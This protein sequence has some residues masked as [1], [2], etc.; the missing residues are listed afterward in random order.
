M[1]VF[2]KLDG[3]YVWVCK[4][5]FTSN[6]NDK[7]FNKKAK[8]IDASRFLAKYP[9]ERVALL[10]DMIRIKEINEMK[11]SMFGPVVQ[12]IPDERFYLS[13]C[14]MGNKYFPGFYQDYRKKKEA[15]EYGAK[16]YGKE[17]ID[18]LIKDKAFD[19]PRGE[20]DMEKLASGDYTPFEFSRFYAN[21]QEITEDEYFSLIKEKERLESIRSAER[22]LETEIKFKRR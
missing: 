9:R 6:F 19:E 21:S 5:A 13:G 7:E 12:Y 18:K 10:T 15:L 1:A 20:K 14:H 16:V 11:P 8:K 4:I 2:F 3:E 22:P 17:M